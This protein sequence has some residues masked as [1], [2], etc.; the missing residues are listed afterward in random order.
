MSFDVIIIY[1][2]AGCMLLGAIDAILGNK[3][4]LGKQFEEGFNA[5]GPLALGMVGI[6][7]LA[8]VIATVL[9]PVL[10]PAF[11]AVGADPSIFASILALDMGGFPLA[12]QLAN[13]PEA[14]KFSGIIIASMLGCTLV[15]SIPV[16]FGLIE[17]KDQPAFAKGLIAGLI[18]IPIGGLIG[19]LVADYDMGLVI[20]NLVPVIV[21]SVLLILG[22]AFIQNKLIRGTI[23]FAKI[24]NIIIYIGLA[25]AAFEYL[26][27]VVLIPGMAP[28]MEG[29]EVVGS[30]AIILLG[31]F[32]FVTIVTRL[33]KTPLEKM[34]SLLKINAKSSAGLIISLANSVP[35]YPMIKDM[36]ERG[37]VMNIA[38]LVPATAVLGDHLGYTGG[39]AP[40]MI[41]PMIL[42]KL[43]AGIIALVLGYWMT[44]NYD[45]DTSVENVEP[46]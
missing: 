15:F 11:E 1:V 17:D 5:M 21:L 8:P 30:V 14:A 9:G 18:T 37:K 32:P 24:L 33:L 10:S 34:G 36:D 35:V 27:G 42:A 25:A 45:T 6:I 13:T 46:N 31:A 3:V 40:D 20:P 29:I 23:I 38:F 26:T 12:E 43:S 44:R 7:C 19:G 39:V 41:T 16:G 4:G 28:I 2:M 22:F